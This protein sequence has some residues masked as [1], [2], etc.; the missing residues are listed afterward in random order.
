M[1]NTDDESTGDIR[2]E[3]GHRVLAERQLPG[4]A[5]QHH[6]RQQHDADTHRDGD[7][8]RSTSVSLVSIRKIDDAEPEQHPV[9][10][11]ATVAEHRH[12]A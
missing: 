10:R 5:G 4:V 7:A 6:D 9:P 1:W 12:L 11:D 8:H 2:A 3:T